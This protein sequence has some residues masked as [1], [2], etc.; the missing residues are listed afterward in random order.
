V[1]LVS[2]AGLAGRVTADDQLG[3]TVVV[4]TRPR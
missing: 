2:A 4:G 1:A 3:A